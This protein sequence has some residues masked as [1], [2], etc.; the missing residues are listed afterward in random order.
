[1]LGWVPHGVRSFVTPEV[2]QELAHGRARER[3]TGVPVEL[4]SGDP[5]DEIARFVESHGV[6]IVVMGTVARTGIAGLE[7]RVTL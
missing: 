2:E 3:L 6:D 5:E 4:V 7:T 1:M